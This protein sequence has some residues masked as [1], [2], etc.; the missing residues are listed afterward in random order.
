MLGGCALLSRP[1]PVIVEAPEPPLLPPLPRP[2]PITMLYVP[3]KIQIEENEIFFCT[4]QKGYE[5]LANSLSDILRYTRQTN[6]LIGAYENDRRKLSPEKV[7]P[8]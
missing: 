5:N 2:E 8:P 6:D 4:P 1:L 3:M 7:K